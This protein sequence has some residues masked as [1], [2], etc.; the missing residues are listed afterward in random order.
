MFNYNLF[1]E[2]VIRYIENPY[3][4]KLN[5]QFDVHFFIKQLCYYSVLK[6][7]LSDRLLH[8]FQRC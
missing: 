3:A 2:Q 8:F 4:D 1:L 7:Y 5:V 6:P